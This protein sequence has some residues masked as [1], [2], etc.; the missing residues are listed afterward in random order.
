MCNNF[1]FG[2]RHAFHTLPALFFCAIRQ[3][4][5]IRVLSTLGL[6]G[7]TSKIPL[8]S[9]FEKRPFLRPFSLWDDN[10]YTKRII[11]QISAFFRPLS[12]SGVFLSFS[13][14]FLSFN[15]AASGR[16]LHPAD[17]GEAVSLPACLTL[18]SKTG[19]RGYGFAFAQ[20]PT[21]PYFL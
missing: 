11:F 6:Q 9:D 8:F 17:T 12:A 4:Y 14:A 21:L 13:R 15:K 3:K 1:G 19:R 20:K 10:N 5:P 18:F 7:H 2:C 16:P